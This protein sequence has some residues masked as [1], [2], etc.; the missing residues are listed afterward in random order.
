MDVSVESAPAGGSQSSSVKG[1]IDETGA[2]ASSPCVYSLAELHEHAWPR[3]SH[4]HAV[5]E[6]VWVSFL[7]KQELYA[8][9][10]VAVTMH[11]FTLVKM[12]FHLVHA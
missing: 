7:L 1:Y 6:H 8:S 4:I 10:K 9:V 3:V 5:C 11:A 2:A 12:H